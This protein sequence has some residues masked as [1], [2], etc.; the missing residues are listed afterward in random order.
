MKRTVMYI[1][2]SMFCLCLLAGCSGCRSNEQKD[3]QSVEKQQGQYAKAQPVPFFEW[4]L[5]RDFMIQLQNKRNEALRTW[6]VWRSDTGVIEGHTESIG[7]PLPYDVQLTNP[8]GREGTNSSLVVEQAEPNGLFSSK[9]TAA[10]WIR[11]VV[12]HN[13]KTMEV[14]IYVEGKVTCYPYPIVVDYEKNRVTRAEA[15]PTIQLEKAKK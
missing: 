6:S 11:S 1:F 15:E 3:R 14:P 7:F 5:E 8:L 9:T 10:T 2:G 4:S 12:T 13:G